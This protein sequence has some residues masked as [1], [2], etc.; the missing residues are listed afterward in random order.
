MRSRPS[1]NRIQDVSYPGLLNQGVGR[2]L[3]RH[4]GK[5]EV[6]VHDHVDVNVP[7]LNAQ[8]ARRRG[9]YRRMGFTQV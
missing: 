1:P 8:Y 4:E 6:I 5:T 3:R 7:V 2:V 9:E